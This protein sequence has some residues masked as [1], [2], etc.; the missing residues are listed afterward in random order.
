MSH[1]KSA[2]EGHFRYKNCLYRPLVSHENDTQDTR[3]IL[4]YICCEKY[5]SQQ[6]INLLSNSGFVGDCIV[7]IPVLLDG[8]SSS[9]TLHKHA[10]VDWFNVSQMKHCCTGA[11]RSLNILSPSNTQKWFSSVVHPLQ[12]SYDALPSSI[13]PPNRMTFGDRN[14][15]SHFYSY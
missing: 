2:H 6:H 7:Q 4:L 8:F 14:L 11:Y 3:H 10:I 1:I 12:L 15:P 5:I 9:C 13:P